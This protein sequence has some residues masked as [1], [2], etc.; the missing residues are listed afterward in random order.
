MTSLR[1][2]YKA[3]PQQISTCL[4]KELLAHAENGFIDK[5]HI[6]EGRY[7]LY[8]NYLNVDGLF[9]KAK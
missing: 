2:K 6:K 1:E 7:E 4:L 3:T 8:K 5:K 9:K